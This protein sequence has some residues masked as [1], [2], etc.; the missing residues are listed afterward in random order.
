MM[1]NLLAKVK[2]KVAIATFPFTFYFED[3]LEVQKMT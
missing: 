1:R 3:V 2:E